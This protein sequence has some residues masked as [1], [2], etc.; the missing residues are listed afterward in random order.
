MSKL[1]GFMGRKSDDE[2]G[3]K[4]WCRGHRQLQ[5]LSWWNEVPQHPKD[6]SRMLHRVITPAAPAVMGHKVFDQAG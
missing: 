6:L 1:G 5:W 3:G 2:P 4:T